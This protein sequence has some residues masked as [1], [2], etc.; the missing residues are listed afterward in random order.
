MSDDAD[1]LRMFADDVTVGLDKENRIESMFCGFPDDVD[2]G[3]IL[4]YLNCLKHLKKLEL[5]P[6]NLNDKSAQYLADVPSL[7][8]LTVQS[9]ELTSTGA[10]IVSRLPDLE[11][12]DINLLPDSH[13]LFT[14]IS[15][16]K[17]LRELAVERCHATDDDLAHF[18]PSANLSELSLRDNP[19]LCGIELGV[20]ERAKITSLH[21]DRTCIGDAAIKTVCRIPTIRKLSLDCTNVTDIGTRELR[22]LIQLETLY[23]GD[24]DSIT[25]VSLSSFA[26]LEKLKRLGLSGTRIST[27]GM[28]QLEL[29]VGRLR[30]LHLPLGAFS[31]QDVARLTK[32]NPDCKISLLK[33]QQS[34]EINRDIGN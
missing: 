13:G 32:I 21:L 3:R 12:L 19:T 7:T 14:A 22:R 17:K 9:L 18:T 27:A 24:N 31:K 4:P 5:A 16:C 23:F 34:R 33:K 28:P 25:D 6:S 11:I 30:A 10:S 26:C 29:I 20:L 8:Y 2:V 1:F 15:H